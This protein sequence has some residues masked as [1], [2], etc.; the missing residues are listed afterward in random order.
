[1]HHEFI[2][3]LYPAIGDTIKIETRVGRY[4]ICQSR[5]GIIENITIQ[6]NTY[7]MTGE[8]TH[9]AY[10]MALCTLATLINV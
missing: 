7:I 10:E 4:E 5:Y 3:P 1:M 9:T 8:P 6:N 2:Y